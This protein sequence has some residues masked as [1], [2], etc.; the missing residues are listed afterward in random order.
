M[1]EKEHHMSEP[2]FTVKDLLETVLSECSPC[3]CLTVDR[4]S[5]LTLHRTEGQF[6]MV[7]VAPVNSERMD[8]L[9]RSVA[10][11]AQAQQLKSKGCAELIYDFE[12]TKFGQPAFGRF[13]VEA[14]AVSGNVM[15]LKFHRLPVSDQPI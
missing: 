10:S 6:G 5:T 1:E 2:E 9:F 4:Q 8:A 14:K 12:T 11:A 15:S 13:R 3:L 7:D